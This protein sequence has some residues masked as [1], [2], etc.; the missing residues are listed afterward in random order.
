MIASRPR[1]FDE[2]MRHIGCDYSFFG[3]A[4]KLKTVS[5]PRSVRHGTHCRQMARSNDDQ[6]VT[7]PNAE[8]PKSYKSAHFAIQKISSLFSNLMACFMQLLNTPSYDR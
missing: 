6:T 2:L 7:S 8:N 5:V 3:L 1:N 4:I